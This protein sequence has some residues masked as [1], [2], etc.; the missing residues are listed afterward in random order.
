MEKTKVL[1]E[2]KVQTRF[3]APLM[4][5]LS[6]EE[7]TEVLSDMGIHDLEEQRKVFESLPEHQ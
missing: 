2:K 7:I 6:F 4:R 3:F 1:Q 5:Q